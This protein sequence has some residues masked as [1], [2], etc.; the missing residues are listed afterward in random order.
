MFGL[1]LLG[2]ALAL[3]FLYSALIIEEDEKE[4]DESN[5]M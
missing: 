5:N 4:E 2:I 1:I 3:I